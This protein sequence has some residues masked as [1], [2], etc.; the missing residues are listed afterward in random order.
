MPP[1]DAALTDTHA[2]DSSPLG[3]PAMSKGRRRI[4]E[5][6]MAA[7]IIDDR[8]LEEALT[9]RA[10]GAGRRER[11]G[12]TI[13]RLGY[14]SE[15]DIA[16]ALATQLGYAFLDDE[17]VEIDITAA[18]RIPP[19]I[20]ERHG[21]LGL[22]VDEDGTLVIATA[23]PTN[24]LA[25]DDVRLAARARRLRVAVVT[26]NAIVEGLKRAYGFG[27][28]AGDLLEQLDD[29]EADAEGDEE[30]VAGA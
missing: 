17:H 22:R 18:A 20:A 6:L 25:L 13:V 8:Q 12:R 11:L 15:E 19:A 21:V 14:A 5:V 2:T 30:D 24:I 28:R 7:G 26:E 3:P 29:A 9:E 10:N 1:F 4:G 27:Q 16:K 23:D